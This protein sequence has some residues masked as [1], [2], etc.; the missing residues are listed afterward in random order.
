MDSYEHP[1]I[2][3]HLSDRAMKQLTLKFSK[4]FSYLKIF[5]MQCRKNIAVEDNK[6]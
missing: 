2:S 6:K 1:E 5:C 4:Y 3:H